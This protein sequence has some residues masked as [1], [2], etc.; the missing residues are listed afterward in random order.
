MEAEK[1]HE[2]ESRRHQLAIEQH[3]RREAAKA[4]RKPARRPRPLATGVGVLGRAG[5]NEGGGDLSDCG[6]RGVGGARRH[7]D[8]SDSD[9]MSGA[10]RPPSLLEKM[11]SGR[12]LQQRE[13]SMYQLRKV[14]SETALTEKAL[15][16]PCNERAIR[17]LDELEQKA[18]MTLRQGPKA[19]RRKGRTEKEKQ[20]EKDVVWAINV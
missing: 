16:R 19:G 18:A 15:H 3:A 6:N 4:G 17:L 14:Q 2:R 12:Y 1:E 7:S 5:I 9:A 20:K 10:R 13:V 8:N 11:S